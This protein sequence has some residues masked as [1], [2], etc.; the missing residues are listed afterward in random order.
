MNL[1]YLVQNN[2]HSPFPWKLVSFVTVFFCAIAFLLWVG[3]MNREREVFLIHKVSSPN[4]KL[5]NLALYYYQNPGKWR[6]IFIANKAELL[7]TKKLYVGQKLKIPVTPA[8]R[9]E[10]LSQLKRH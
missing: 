1:K 9:Q 2:Q 8:R 7:K 10:I 4:E 5:R 3:Y 6:K